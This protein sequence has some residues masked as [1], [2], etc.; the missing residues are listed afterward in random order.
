MEAG[1]RHWHGGA[2]FLTLG[3]NAFGAE[4]LHIVEDVFPDFQG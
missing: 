2:A 1:A 3:V 4:L